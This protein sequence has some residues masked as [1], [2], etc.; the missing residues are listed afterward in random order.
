[1]SE[2]IIGLVV[3]VVKHS[4]RH[5]VV[6]LFTRSHGRMSFLSPVSSKGKGRGRNARL[7]LLS[8]IEGEVRIKQTD[9]LSLL[10][11]V[12]SPHVW[13]TLY[14]SPVKSS[15]VI[16]LAEFLNKLLRDSAPDAAL[17]DYILNS[18]SVL[19]NLQEGTSNFH[20]TFL[21][22]LSHY[23]GIAPL[24][25]TWKEEYFFDLRAG[26]FTPFRPLHPDFL[27]EEE[28]RYLTVLMR[29][30]YANMRFFRFNGEMRTHILNR[31][32]HYYSIHLPGTSNL[33]SPSILSELFNC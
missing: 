26:Q 24:V 8:I 19:D 13:R 18:L 14:F 17:W 4:D 2:K 27:N 23:I 29:I 1:M 10:P 15:I 9:S 3:S 25:E 28:S 12:T 22:G 31:I 16:F 20:I 11:S 7:A 32:L 30:N 33:R 6:S 21:T 5:N